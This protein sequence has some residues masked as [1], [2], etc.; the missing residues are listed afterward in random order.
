[1]L[2]AA[3]PRSEVAVA[4]AVAVAAAAV[5]AAQPPLRAVARPWPWPSPLLAWA[6]VEGVAAAA[7]AAAAQPR[8]RHP[9]RRPRHSPRAAEAVASEAVVGSHGCTSHG[10]VGPIGPADLSAAVSA[11]SVR[12]KVVLQNS[13]WVG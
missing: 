13:T 12:P 2:Q 3:R 1:M 7:V 10:P 11:N 6:G 5:A 9:L 8:P 4:V